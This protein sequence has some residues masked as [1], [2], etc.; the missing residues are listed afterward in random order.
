MH[1]SLR[2]YETEAQ[3]ACRRSIAAVVAVLLARA[4]RLVGEGMR[5]D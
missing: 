4:V 5:H 1:I 2:K 3:P